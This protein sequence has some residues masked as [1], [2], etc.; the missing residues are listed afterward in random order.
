MKHPPALNIVR[1]LA[2]LLSLCATC[3]PSDLHAQDSNVSNCATLGGCPAQGSAWG[4]LQFNGNNGFKRAPQSTLRGEYNRFQVVAGYKYMWSLCTGDGAIIPNGSPALRLTLKTTANSIICTSAGLNFGSCTNPRL[5]WTATFTGEVRVQISTTDCST[6]SGPN[7]YTMVWRCSSCG[8]Y[9][10]C[11]SQPDIQCG[12]EVMTFMPSGYGAFTP[13]YTRCTWDNDGAGTE[14]IFT[15][16][17]PYTGLFRIAITG[18]NTYGPYYWYYRPYSSG[19]SDMGWT[20]M[21]DILQTG[22]TPYFTFT[23]GTTYYIMIDRAAATT[24]DWLFNFMVECL[25]PVPP[26][27]PTD[28][29]YCGMPTN[30]TFGAGE[31]YWSAPSASCGASTPGVEQIYTFNPN[32][33][34][35][36]MIEQLSSFGPIDWFVKVGSPACTSTGWQCIGTLDGTQTSAIFTM[37]AG[38]NYRILAD[39]RTTQGGNVQFKLLCPDNN[40]CLNTPPI[41]C[42]VPYTGTIQGGLGIFNP[43]SNWCGTS[44]PGM[45]RIVSFTAPYTGDYTIQQLAAFNRMD[46]FV[47]PQSAGCTSTGWTCIGALNGAATSPVFSLQQGITYLIM[48]DAGDIDHSQIQFQIN[49][50]SA[51]DAC[52]LITTLSGCNEPMTLSFGSGTGTYLQPSTGCGTNSP[53]R[54]RIF[55]YMAP[56][57]GQRFFE[58]LTSFGPVSYYVKPQSGGCN[59]TGWT[60]LG[61]ISG[62][63]VTSA[64]SMAAGTSYLVMLDPVSTTGGTVDLLLGCA[65]N[66]NVC[67]T[68]TLGDIYCG[69]DMT[70]DVPAGAGGFI[71]LPGCGGPM[72]GRERVF[73]FTPSASGPH[74]ILQTGAYATVRYAFKQSGFGTCVSSGWTCAGYVQGTDQTGAVNLT[75]GTSYW[76][77]I[78]AST[79]TGGVVSFRVECP[80]YN[81]CD[82][83]PWIQCEATQRV[84]LG[85]GA[86]TKELN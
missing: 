45:E 4:T 82:D 8:D 29:V 65:P 7:G 27:P 41:S 17:P 21:G 63:G 69:I 74:T 5:Q 42:G 33:T 67:L 2:V 53:G 43:P 14:R 3:F 52:A 71:D 68:S 49:C 36:Y 24:Q 62:G 44:T 12:Q 66:G 19:C 48:A 76:L 81:A 86:G 56:Q 32:Q 70:V 51:Y 72:P 39:P 35:Q 20:C 55:T 28:P 31:G 47:K 60:C 57:S 13:A 23:G 75:A 25:P 22:E 78:D 18:A 46:Y 73:L 15:F 59:G 16:T 34:G 1:C 11:M 50:T 83:R 84:V 6:G 79:M 54:E 85:A 64:Y 80:N 37:Q 10:P 30:A 61:T 26:C 58:Q 9:D 38:T 77:L 40:P